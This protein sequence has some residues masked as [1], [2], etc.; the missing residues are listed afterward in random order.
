M[1][2]HYKVECSICRDWL[3][4]TTQPHHYRT[5]TQ[6]ERIEHFFQ[7]GKYSHGYCPTCFVLNLRNDGI[8]ESDIETAIREI[9]KLKEEK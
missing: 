1:T 5:P 8:P 7:K 9:Q 4:E 2:P 6:Q 3:D